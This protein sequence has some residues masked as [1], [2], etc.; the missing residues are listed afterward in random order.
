[1]RA[2]KLFKCLG[3]FQSVRSLTH[4]LSSI[5][6]SFVTM[7]AKMWHFRCNRE[8]SIH[9]EICWFAVQIFHNYYGMQLD[10]FRKR[11][12][13]QSGMEGGKLLEYELHQ[14]FNAT[15]RSRWTNDSLRVLCFDKITIY[16]G[17][18]SMVQTCISLLFICLCRTRCVMRFKGCSFI[19]FYEIR[20]ETNTA[21]MAETTNKNGMFYARDKECAHNK[22]ERTRTRPRAHNGWLRL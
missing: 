14:S 8:Q 7:D 18:V 17:S 4:T 3:I 5:T 20:N 9:L 16:L 12:A 21:T 1:M 10:C 15:I 2:S 19:L 22:R 13:N 6:A 11:K